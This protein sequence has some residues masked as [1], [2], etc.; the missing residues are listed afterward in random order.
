[1]TY[2]RAQLDEAVRAA[3]EA[4]REECA[5]V[6]DGLSTMAFMKDMLGLVAADKVAAAIRA[7]GETK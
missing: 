2:T 1:M 6:A 7:R 5:K 3:V 4:E